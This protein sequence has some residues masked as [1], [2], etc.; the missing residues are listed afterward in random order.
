MPCGILYFASN[1]LSHKT[2]T[3]PEIFFFSNLA[4]ASHQKITTRRTFSRWQIWSLGGQIPAPC[5]PAHQRKHLEGKQC[6]SPWGSLPRS[7]AL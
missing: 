2:F 5:D 4:L 7:W 6:F 1:T 3:F